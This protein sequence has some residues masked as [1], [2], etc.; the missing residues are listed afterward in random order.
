MSNREVVSY[1]RTVVP[2]RQ[3]STYV[4]QQRTGRTAEQQASR[5]ALDAFTNQLTK[6]RDAHPSGLVRSEDIVSS[7]LSKALTFGYQLPAGMKFE[8][9]ELTLMLEVCNA[10]DPQHAHKDFV[11]AVLTEMGRRLGK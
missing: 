7:P 11:Y 8:V 2:D 5:S 9:Q 10:V 4:E 3:V 1:G 6:L